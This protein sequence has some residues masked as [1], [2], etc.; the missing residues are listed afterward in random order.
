VFAEQGSVTIRAGDDV[1]LDANS[2][3]VAA[4]GIVIHGDFDDADADYGTRMI[5]R[6]KLVAGAVVTAG[7]PVG[8]YVPSLA[9]PVHV[10]DIYAGADSDL[11]QFGDPSGIAG[12]QT[13]GDPG[14]I[15]IGAKTRVH[16]GAGEDRLNV[17]YLQSASATT[18]PANQTPAEHTLRLD[19][20]GGTDYYAVHTLGSQG[21]ARNYVINVLDTGAPADGADELAIFGRDSTTV[22]AAN[23]DIFL[24]RAAA[25]LP[26]ETANRPGYVALLHGDVNTYADVV[27]GNESSNKVQRIGYDTAL[28]G[29]LSVYGLGGNDVFASDDTTVNVTLDGG[30]GND[31]FRIGQI[32][33]SKR[34]VTG[35]GLLAQDVFPSMVATTRGWLS[36]GISAP[37]VVHGGTGNDTFTVYANQAELRL[38]GDDD[39]DAFVVRAFALAAVND[40]GTETWVDDTIL[41][42]STGVAIPRIGS[43]FSTARPLDIRTGGGEDEVQYNLNA[44]VSIDGGTGFDKLVVLGTEFADDIVVTDQG[45][46]GAGISA[47]YTNIEAIEIDGLEGDDEFF[48][49]ST[50][51]GVSYRII[52][53]LGSDTINIAGDVSEDIVVRELEGASGNVNHRLKSL[54]ALYNGLIATASTTTSPRLVRRR[55]DRGKQRLHRG[56]RRRARR[57][58][59]AT[60]CAWRLRR[61]QASSSMSPCPRLV[62]RRKRRTTRCA[63]RRGSPTASATPS[64]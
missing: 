51:F 42:D 53:G 56:P 3:I 5:L 54:D 47:R 31:S 1:V 29:R 2:E 13:W 38:E 43:G 27:T 9:A 63:T 46:F 57:L 4:L 10:T 64:G 37:M 20:Q 28:N 49:L 45:I 18:S 15:F 59:T 24:L 32:F 41:L 58:P 22:G 60:P 30:A 62:R 36:S 48:V 6:G 39:D 34:D 52:G 35:G 21:V 14:F 8:S 16:A 17:Y 11:I 50:A 40:N 33:G 44:P 12:S 55:R 19:G 25:F 61:P 23:D 7:D 26:G